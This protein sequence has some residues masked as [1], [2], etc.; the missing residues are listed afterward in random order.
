MAKRML[1]QLKQGTPLKWTR[2]ITL[3]Q[4]ELVYKPIIGRSY[5]IAYSDMRLQTRGLGLFITTTKNNHDE[6]AIAL[7]EANGW[8]GYVLLL[9]LIDQAQ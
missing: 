4:H 1:D 3:H 9:Q 8:P 5:T 7:D 6:T 2:S